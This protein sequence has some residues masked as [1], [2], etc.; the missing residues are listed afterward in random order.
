MN[1][2]QSIGTASD[3]I[4]ATLTAGLE[5]EFGRGAGE[6]LAGQFLAAEEAD[7][8]WDVRVEERWLGSY[9]GGEEGELELDRIAIWGLLDGCWFIALMLVDGERMAHGMTRVRTFDSRTEAR[10]AMLDAR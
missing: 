9:G 3:D 8:R 1:M 4:A 5:I 10:E 2:V 7:Y 6:A